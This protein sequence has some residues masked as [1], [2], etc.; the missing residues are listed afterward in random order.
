M[1]RG[2]TFRDLRR[3]SPQDVTTSNHFRRLRPGAHAVGQGNWSSIALD[4]MEETTWQ[5][6]VELLNRLPFNN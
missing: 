5:H 1:K 6:P 2:N 4:D 3:V